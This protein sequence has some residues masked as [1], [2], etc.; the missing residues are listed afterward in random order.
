MRTLIHNASKTMADQNKDMALKEESLKAQTPSTNALQSLY[1]TQLLQSYTPT[2]IYAQKLQ[3]KGVPGK[4]V[5]NI[6]APFVSNGVEY[7]AGRVESRKSETDSLVMFFMRDGDYWTLDPNAPV[8]ALQDP[9]MTKINNKLVLGGVQIQ[10]S[11]QANEIKYRTVFYT[12]KDLA[13]LQKCAQGPVRMKD[14]R[15]IQL[16]KGIGVFTRP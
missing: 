4:D 12:G 13:S 14:I 3:F 6:T 16:E 10:Y 5:Y 8:F 9:C 11:A 2:I 7:I 15:L 1:T